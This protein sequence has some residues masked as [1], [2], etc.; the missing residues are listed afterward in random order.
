MIHSGWPLSGVEDWPQRRQDTKKREVNHHKGSP[1]KHRT[2]N[3][4]GYLIFLL[5]FHKYQ[6]A[7]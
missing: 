5:F 2:K 1:A 7:M 6:G 3:L 4:K